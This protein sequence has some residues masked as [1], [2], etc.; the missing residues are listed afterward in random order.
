VQF[1]AGSTVGRLTLIE[2]AGRTKQSRLLWKCKCECGTEKVVR[3]NH[4]KDGSTSSCGCTRNIEHGHA[5]CGNYSPTYYTWKTMRERCSNSN[6][7]HFKYYGGKGV[8]VC[9]RWNDFENFLADMGARPEGRSLNRINND[10]DYEKS[11]C[12]WA[13]RKEQANNTRRKAA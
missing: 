8:K 6:H 11:N 5:R 9:D 10:G 12:R 2:K 3:D 7:V 1:K 4:L 13:T